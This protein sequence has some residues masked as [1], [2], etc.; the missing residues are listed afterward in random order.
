MCAVQNEILQFHVPTRPLAPRPQA[1]L[2]EN[3]PRRQRGTISRRQKYKA[4]VAVAVEK[5]ADDTKGQTCYICTEAVHWKTK[6]GLVRGCACRGTAGFV[7]VSCLA[8]QAKILVAE[9]EEN[10]LD[11][12]R[13]M[14]RWNRWHTCSLCKQKHHGVVACALGWAC[15]KTYVGRSETVTS[16]EVVLLAMNLLGGGLGDANQNEDA[17]IVREAELAMWQ[18]LGHSESN[19]L[20]V[21]SN[22]ASTYQELKRYDESLR[23]RREVYSRKVKLLGG[24]HEKTILEAANYANCLGGLQRHAEAKALLR[25]VVPVARRVLGDNHQIT[26]TMRGYYA[27]A[28]FNDNG[29]TLEEIR[30]AVTTIDET[31]RTARQMLGFSHPLAVALGENLRIMRAALHAREETATGST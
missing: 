26:L 21:Q 16:D 19:M 17:L 29:A 2:Q 3:S 27:E 22:L 31:V 12:D 4:A 1:D 6:E 20:V 13:F 7:H 28:L 18:R 10:N 30:V 14:P 24:E 25:K 9:G 11:D 23:M 8:E 5:C 15:W